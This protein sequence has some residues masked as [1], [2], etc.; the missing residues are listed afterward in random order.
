M[1]TQSISKK[2]GRFSVLALALLVAFVIMPSVSH[3]AQNNKE[4]QIT[5]ASYIPPNYPYVGPGQ[6]L[7]VDMVNKRCKGIVHINAYWGGTLLKGK[8]LLPG[9]QAGTADLILHTGAYLLGTYPII[10]VQILPV[11][12]NIN[13]SFQGLKMG[14]PL[15]KLQ[16]DILKKKNLYQLATAGMVPEFLWTRTK[17]VRKPADMKGLKIRVAGKVEAKVIQ[18]LGAAPVTM[19]S[20]EL[21]QALQRGVVDG[22]LMNPWT[23]QGRGIEEFCKYMLV[24]TLSCQTTPV[25]VLWDKWNSWP[26]DVRKALTDV[27]RDWEPGYIGPNPD[28]ILRDDQ[29]KTEVIPF[30]EKKGMTAIYPT[31]EEARAFQQAVRPV[32]DWWVKQVGEDVGRKA[33]K[34][35]DFKY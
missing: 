8:Q 29:L 2:A 11:W 32:I 12:K 20:A 22:A 16:N 4:F 24:M 5:A 17:L 19:P 1:R 21:P 14:S 9:L 30:Y 15:A 34:Y 25:Y 28:A 18:A 3:G 13:T 31:K 27:A 23:A 26:E 10:G 7:F 6:G 35:T 33:L